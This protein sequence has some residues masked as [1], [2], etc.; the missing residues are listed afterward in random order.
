MFEDPIRH[1]FHCNLK[2]L[3]FSKRIHKQQFATSK[4]LPNEGIR[5][6][7]IEN[8]NNNNKTK[9]AHKKADYLINIKFGKQNFDV[10]PPCHSVK[11]NTYKKIIKNL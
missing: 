9:Y 5:D 6:I 4:R 11:K 8:N 3:F 1:V 10:T 2:F 7:N